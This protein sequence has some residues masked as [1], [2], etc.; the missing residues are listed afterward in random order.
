MP[1]FLERPVF[2]P[3]V[4][5]F[6]VA[7]PALGFSADPVSLV[8]AKDDLTKAKGLVAQLGDP[9]FTVRENAQ[10]DLATMGRKALQSLVSGAADSPDP[11]VR[12]RCRKLIPA[13]REEDFQ[14]RVDSFLADVDGKYKHNLPGLD[15]FFDT[16]GKSKEARQ[17]FIDLLKQDDN[18][19]LI[20]LAEGDPTQLATAVQ[21]R[22]QDLYNRQYNRTVMP[23]GVMVQVAES[24]KPKTLDVVTLLIADTRVTG[25][26]MG[27][28]QVISNPAYSMQIVQEF[29]TAAMGTGPT[30]ELIRKVIGRWLDTRVD[31]LDLYYGMN[32]LSNANQKEEALRAAEKL[33]AAK[34]GASTYKGMAISTLAR[35]KGKDSIPQILPYLKDETLCTTRFVNA[36]ERYPILMKDIALAALVSLTEQKLADYEFDPQGHGGGPVVSYANQWFKSDEDRDKGFEKWAKWTKANPKLLEVK[37]EKEKK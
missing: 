27:R 25:E 22:A 5:A 26:H 21:N 14:A 17:L 4:F 32:F 16:T 7:G 1:A 6:F 20:S 15:L 12:L 11:E 18:R 3:V 37:K 33:L 23:N 35:F 2:R 31:P 29:R 28:R 13:A 8:V 34:A 36:N 30:A 24:N 9:R 19:R 10:R